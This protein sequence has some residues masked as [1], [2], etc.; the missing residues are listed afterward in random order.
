MRLDC[1][2]ICKSHGSVPILRDVTF[3]IPD[4]KSLV[5]IGPSGSGKSTLLKMVAGLVVADSGT[6][7][8]N[9]VLLPKE[10]NE[11]IA[12]RRLIGTVFQSWNLFP[13]MTA[14]QNVSLPLFHV[15]GLS[16]KESFERSMQLLRRFGLAAHAD[17]RPGE[18]SGGQSQRVAIVRAVAIRPHL[19]LFDEPTSALDP[20][21]TAEILDLIA[22]LK[23]E[24][25][26]F[27]L[28]S[29]H[30]SFAKKIADYVAF[31]QEGRV[32][33]TAPSKQFFAQPATDESR[34]FLAKILKY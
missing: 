30:V 34:A 4:C 14:L 21:M 31:V 19:L 5:L 10:E 25:S 27:I 33:E 7:A 26:D 22:E 9:E 16:K 3:S 8:V 2:N 24:G 6:I 29:H 15:H 17:K 28:V 20:I 11:L 1:K 12:Y 18:L 13:H 23:D 32:V